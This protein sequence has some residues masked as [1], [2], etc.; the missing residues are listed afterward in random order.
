LAETEAR[1]AILAAE[2]KLV[3]CY[4]C[5]MQVEMEGDGDVMVCPIITCGVNTCCKCGKAAHSPNLCILPPEY[6]ETRHTVEE[7]MTHARLRTCG[8]CKAAFIKVDG[9]NNITCACG[10]HICY[11]CNKMIGSGYSHFN[12]P[13]STCRLYTDSLSDDKQAMLA[14]GLSVNTDNIVNVNNLL[15][16]QT[17]ANPNVVNPNVA[18]AFAQQRQWVQ[19]H[20]VQMALD[21][22]VIRPRKPMTLEAKKKRADTIAAKKAAKKAALVAA[23][24]AI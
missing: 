12:R 8:K 13:D 17:K 10:A 1:A 23:S 11:I 20:W 18:R 14:A 9:C 15:E 16:T 4:V 21:M 24:E 7:A 3:Q 6:E 5:A 19:E 2:L 22:G